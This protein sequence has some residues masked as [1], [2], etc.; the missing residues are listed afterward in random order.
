L[1]CGEDEDAD[2]VVALEDS[3]HHRLF[4]F[5]PSGLSLMAPLC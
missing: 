2:P 5:E 4:I 3:R 1:G